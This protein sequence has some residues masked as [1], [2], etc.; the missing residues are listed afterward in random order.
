MSLYC[1]HYGKNCDLFGE[2]SLM[3]IGFRLSSFSC[4][5]LLATLAQLGNVYLHL[6]STLDLNPQPILI[7]TSHLS[8][9][10]PPPCSFPFTITPFVLS[11][12][13][14][15][16]PPILKLSLPPFHLW[17]PPLPLSPLHSFTSPTI[18]ISYLYRFSCRYRR[19]IEKTHMD[20]TGTCP[21]AIKKLF[22]CGRSYGNYLFTLYMGV[23][24]KM[25]YQWRSVN[26]RLACNMFTDVRVCPRCRT[27]NVFGLRLP[28]GE[29]TW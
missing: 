13:F 11:S 22:R 12:I 26:S 17:P 5:L 14:V 18:L 8:L 19:Y 16:S 7:V 10:T 2:S 9:M 24:G 20:T 3:Q 15:S 6:L 27:K 28:W 23:K 21:P 1:C 25:T 4:H 29:T